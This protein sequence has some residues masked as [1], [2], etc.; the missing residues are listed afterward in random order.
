MSSVHQAA[1]KS[2][3][4]SFFGDSEY[5]WVDWERG[6]IQ[7]CSLSQDHRHLLHRSRNSPSSTSSEYESKADSLQKGFS[8]FCVESSSCFSCR[9]LS[10]SG[11]QILR[12]SSISLQFLARSS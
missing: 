7:S 9:A 12:R 1:S 11:Q 5:S 4:I 2:R 3:G 10:A 8:S 6:L